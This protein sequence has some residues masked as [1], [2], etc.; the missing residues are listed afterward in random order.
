MSIKK[1]IPNFITSLNLLSGCIAVVIAIKYDLYLASFFICLSAIFDFFDGMS[2]RLLN[3]KSDIGKELDSLA[4]LISFGLAPGLII[5]RLLSISGDVFLK[6]N[7]FNIL[8]FFALIIPVFSAL[9]LAKFNVD[10]NQ[11]KSFIGLPTPANAIF[12]AAFPLI[13]KYNN[14]AFF[15][16]LFSNSYFLIVI[17]IIFSYLLVAKIPMFSL[18]ISNLSWKDNKLR[19]I[20]ILLSLL[21]MAVFRYSGIPMVIILY[22]LLSVFDN[23]VLKSKKVRK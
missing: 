9:R 11:T 2:A 17:S 3:V 14:I 16:E 21:L 5:F 22:I 4:D 23:T 10:V 8:P 1:H 20:F 18:K 7:D 15:N 13:L 19:Y 12:M 6:I